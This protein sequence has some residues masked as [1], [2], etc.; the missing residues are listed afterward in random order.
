[1]AL[2]S[3]RPS[4]RNDRSVRLNKYLAQCGLGSRRACEHLIESGF[5][6]VDDQ[7]IREQGVCITPGIQKVCNNGVEVRPQRRV[8]LVLN[9]PKDVVCTSHDPQGRR[10]FQSLLPATL[11]ARVYT[12]GRLDRNSEGLLI[13][14]ND[15]DLALKMTHPRYEVSKTYHVWC[16]TALTPDQIQRMRRGVESEGERLATDAVVALH[17]ENAYSHVYELRIHEGKNRHIRRMFEALGVEIHRLKR[18]ALGPLR[19]SHLRS[20]EWRYLNPDEVDVLR[21][22]V[23]GASES[24]SPKPRAGGR[25][26]DLRRVA[27]PRPG[28]RRGRPEPKPQFERRPDRKKPSIPNPVQRSGSRPTPSCPR[29]GR[30]ER[31]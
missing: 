23:K 18:V 3:P 12:I 10:T 14:T 11:P 9:K 29:P 7:V 19:L 20:G 5:I 17:S 21:Q 4:R 6:T 27:P 22:A 15:G 1:M 25:P 26:S 31:R 2:D 24:T 30:L 8:Y 13:V 16:R 28:R